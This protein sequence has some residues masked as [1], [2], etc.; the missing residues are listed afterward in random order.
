MTWR[1]ATDAEIAAFTSGDLP[2]AEAVS[3]ALHIDECPACE[4]RCVAEEPLADVFAAIDDPDIPAD[5]IAQ[6]QENLGDPPSYGPEPAIA[7][8]LLGGAG[9]L[10]LLAGAPTDL[11]AGGATVL[12]ACVTA[13]TV[14]LSRMT[15][16]SLMT[17]ALAGGLLLACVFAAQ[18]IER[19]RSA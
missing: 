18:R 12:S 11:L 19:R 14:L 15:T 9:V 13:G 16:P 6:I 17:T 4:A 7:A 3:L 1:H 2:E 5:L 10:L 8:G